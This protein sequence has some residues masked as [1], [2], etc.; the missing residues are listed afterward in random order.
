VNAGTITAADFVPASAPPPLDDSEIHLWLF[1]QWQRIADAA[2]ASPA[3]DLLAAYLDRSVEAIH[4][5]RGEHGK[6]HLADTSLEF[7]LSHT[8]DALLLAVSRNNVLGVDLESVGRRTRPALELAR[9]F[10]TNDEATALA[11]FPEDLRQLAFL[12]LWCAKEA[13]L[14]AEGGG[15]SS[16]LDRFA[17]T[18]DAYG[19]VSSCA[20]NPWHL[21]A[22]AP[23]PAHIGALAHR[24]P[25]GRVRAFVAK[26]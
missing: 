7:N 16:G 18:L 17:F 23:S 24:E 8:T 26:T 12:R 10:F 5:E 1:P 19:Q 6:P 4:I 9:R 22:V 15:I 2:H 11:T 3:R 21:H 13:A 14:K 20:G 25:V